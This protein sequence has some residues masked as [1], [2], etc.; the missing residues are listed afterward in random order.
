MIL[1]EFFY[2][3]ITTGITP[4]SMEEDGYVG[5]ILAAF[6]VWLVYNIKVRPLHVFVLIWLNMFV[7]RYLGNMVEGYFFSNV[8]ISGYTFFSE[9]GI[10]I[11]M[12]L[13]TAAATGFILLHPEFNNSLWNKSRAFLSRRED[14]DWAYRIAL[15]TVLFLAVYYAFGIM[16]SP[17]IHQRY[18]DISQGLNIPAV[19]VIVP[20]ELFRGF[21]IT[22]ALVPLTLAIGTGKDYVFF[23]ASLMMFIPGFMVPLIE[24][25]IPL[26]VSPYIIIELVAFSLVVGFIVS[27]LFTPPS[28]RAVKKAASDA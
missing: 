23:A 5:V 15:S 22:L 11:I 1:I 8:F 21:I 6:L 4:R 28:S 7:I 26:W 2:S 17:F 10:A 25:G 18:P 12:S 27:Y 9:L 3:S 24:N 20:L 19:Y 16:A 14:R 13:L